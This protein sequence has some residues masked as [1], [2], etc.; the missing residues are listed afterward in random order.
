MVAL[1]ILAA[2]AFAQDLVITGTDGN[3]VINGSPAAEAIYAGAGNDVVNA[4]GGDDDLDGGPGADVLNGGDG[5]DSVAYG[6]V[7]GVD[8]S[9]DSIANDGTPGEGDNVGG[10]VEDVFGTDGADKLIGSPAANTIDAGAGDDR[11]SGGPGEDTLFGGDGDDVIDSRDGQRDRVECGPGDDTATIDRIDIVSSDCERR[12]KPPVTI[13]P[14]L[15]ILRNRHRLIISSIV[16]RSS[17]V[18]ACVKR[19]HPAS[20]PSRAILTRASVAL[21]AGRTVRLP[22]PRRISGATIEIGVT[23]RGADTRCVRYRIGRR[24]S[25]VVPLHVACTSVARSRA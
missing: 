16:A 15:T 20:P 13:T 23:A 2:T 22:L 21:D 8:V 1:G 25:S 24:F 17:V 3:D 18:I 11:V 9:L 19:C 12:A 7:S 5:S 6:G 14:G 10:D 4:G